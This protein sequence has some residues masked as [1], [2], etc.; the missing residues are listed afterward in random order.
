M[1]KRVAYAG[2]SPEDIVVEKLEPPEERRQREREEEAQ[3][4]REE[5]AA[6]RVPAALHEALQALSYDDLG[7]LIASW[8]DVWHYGDEEAARPFGRTV[9]DIRVANWRALRRHRCGDEPGSC[10]LK[11]G[12]AHAR[13]K[14]VWE[15]VIRRVVSSL[16]SE[17]LS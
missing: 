3:A 10:A 4:A 17:V 8:T 5:A 13:G 2:Q 14:L 9:A 15:E 11:P 6:L 16:T 1:L 12:C 7:C